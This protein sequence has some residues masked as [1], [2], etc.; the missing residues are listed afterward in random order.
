MA[1]RSRKRA[2]KGASPDPGDP[3]GGAAGA[4][5]G[6]GGAAG[7]AGGTAESQPSFEESLSELEAIVDRLEAG[8][9]PLE[10]ALAAF[11]AGV[12]LTRRCAEQLGAAERKVEVLTRN[13][14]TWVTRP[15]EELSEADD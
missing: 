1:A 4:A 14:S 11:E 15:F 5:E 2:G 10:E 12:V 13:G 7:G 9:L 8:E 6:A 3:G